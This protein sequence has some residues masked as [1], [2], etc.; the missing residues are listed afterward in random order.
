MARVHFLGGAA[1]VTGS[2]FLLEAGGGAV[3]VDCGMF[4]GTRSI[5]QRNWDDPLFSRRLPD[6]VL[7]THAHIDHTGYLPRLVGHYGYDGP[8]LATPATVDLLGIM[9]P[10]SAKIQEEQAAYANKKGYSRHRP[11]LP[12]YTSQDAEATLR[13]LRPVPYHEPVATPAGTARFS[14]AG[15]ILGSAHV[16]V[17]A[18]GK[19]VVFSGDVGRWDV[20]VLKDPEPPPAADLALLESTYGNRLHAPGTDPTASL[21][22][23][24]NRVVDREGVMVIPAFSLGR[25]QEVLFRLR[26]LEEDGTVPVLPIFLDSPMAIEATEIYRRHRLEHDLEATALASEGVGPLR[27]ARLEVTRTV[28]ESKSL[29][30]LRGPA[31]IISA[32]GMA[33]AGRVVH[34]LKRL[35]PDP[36]NLVSF[37]GYQGAGT[38]GRALVDGARHVKI[39]GQRV[40]VNAEVIRLDAFSA[41]ADADE[42]VRW[43]REAGGVPQRVALVHG[44]QPSREALAGRLRREFPG[45]DVLLPRR[46]ATVDV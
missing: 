15:H 7:I 44:E 13:L 34:H 5:R 31:I 4:Q 21:A 12:L 18:D 33:T 17:E 37:V 45:I 6:Q 28:D 14:F 10:D 2:R 26:E 3:L 19:T 39:H 20:P 32:S 43:L 30:G 25:T 29:N 46:G 36:R 41:H 40:P 42:L 9:L 24:V 23:A 1:T 8:I 27:P 16:T 38:R 22:A 11:A 35:L